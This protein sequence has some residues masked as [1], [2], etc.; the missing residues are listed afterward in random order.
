M[1]C[2]VAVSKRE[3]KAKQNKRGKDNARIKQETSGSCGKNR[4]YACMYTHVC[5]DS[6]TA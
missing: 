4:V 3:N 2:L 6:D 1:F 5:I